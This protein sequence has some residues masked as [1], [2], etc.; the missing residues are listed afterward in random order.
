M[1]FIKELLIVVLETMGI[2]LVA[3]GLGFLAGIWIGWVGLAVSGVVLLCAA[4]LS[5][6]QQRPRPP[7]GKR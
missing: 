7:G 3:A 5:A 4:G 1:T 2:L 6:R